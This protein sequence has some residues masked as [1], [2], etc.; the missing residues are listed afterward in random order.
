MQC[1]YKVLSGHTTKLVFLL[2]FCVLIAIYGLEGTLWTP[3]AAYQYLFLTELNFNYQH[4]SCLTLSS[5]LY[6]LWTYFIFGLLFKIMSLSF[7]WI[8]CKKN[9][10]ELLS[11]IVK[12]NIILKPHEYYRTYSSLLFETFL[13]K[14]PT[15]LMHLVIGP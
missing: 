1:L 15:S 12:N 2:F 6:D 8:Y 5:S 11:D 13:S 3:L 4:F 14:C 9:D 10:F 7:L